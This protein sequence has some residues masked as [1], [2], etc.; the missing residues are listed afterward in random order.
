MFPVFAHYVLTLATPFG[1][2]SLS[3]VASQSRSNPGFDLHHDEIE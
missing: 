1:R 3:W 2:S